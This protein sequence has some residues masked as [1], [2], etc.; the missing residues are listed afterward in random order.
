MVL[1]RSA[2]TKRC[3]AHDAT[4]RSFRLP[5]SARKR[6]HDHHFGSAVEG[7]TQ[8]DC[9]HAVDKEFDMAAN[10][11]LLVDDAKAQTR[12]PPIEIRE[13]TAQGRSLDAYY[14]GI[15]RVVPQRSRD[16]NAHRDQRAASEP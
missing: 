10:A 3:S 14:R 6:A 15:R 8:I 13:N 12:K 5:L 9:L 11:P 4:S 2:S 16:E 7:P 1:C